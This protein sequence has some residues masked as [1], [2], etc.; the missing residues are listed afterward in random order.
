[1]IDQYLVRKSNPSW[2]FNICQS[3]VHVENASLAHLCY[4][5]RLIEAPRPSGADPES[6]VGG[7]SFVVTDAGAP[8][9][10]GD[11]YSALT[12][13]TD[14]AVT[15]PWV[16]P[17]VMLLVATLVER[18]Y[19]AHHA[20]RSASPR[21]ARFLPALTGDIVFLQPS[22]FNSTLAHLIFDDSRARKAPEEGGLG[23]NG[24][25]TTMQGTCQVVAV[26]K[27]GSGNSMQV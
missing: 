27:R 25:I 22:I 12:L 16:S 23:Y 21:L 11:V 5:A 14:G 9:T 24:R 3:F 18:Y 2:I 20:L 4:E 6:D 15:F 8:P 7:G 10:Y 1:M 19:L 26:R 17:T 13:L